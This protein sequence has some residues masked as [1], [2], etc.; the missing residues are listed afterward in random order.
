MNP[1]AVRR[2]QNRV[3]PVGFLAL[4]LLLALL[5]TAL[6]GWDEKHFA[7]GLFVGFFALALGYRSLGSGVYL[8]SLAAVVL[9]VGWFSVDLV[10]SNLELARDVLRRR[11]RFAPAILGFDVSALGSLHTALLVSL[12]SLTPGSVCIDLDASERILFV[13]T[14][15][16]GD[17]REARARVRRY[18]RL[19]RAMAG[20]RG[21]PK[22][23]PR[24]LPREA[25]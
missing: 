9:L 3:S 12:I 5:W 8:R 16:G 13:H 24:P 4:H 1:A 18:T 21:L 25:R 14:L 23:H 17:E 10:A 22:P 19:L 20:A 15:Y 6:L 7:V 2:A 11:P